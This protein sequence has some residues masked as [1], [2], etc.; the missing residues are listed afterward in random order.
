MA[1]DPKLPATFTPSARLLLARARAP[2]RVRAVAANFGNFQLEQPTG[3]LR[4]R[5]SLRFVRR[6]R[7]ARTHSDTNFVN[8]QL[9]QPSGNGASVEAMARMDLSPPPCGKG[10]VG[11][12]HRRER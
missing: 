8:F 2:A 1:S 11:A 4:S 10:W 12:R 3:P 6:R 9:E 5:Q 7:V